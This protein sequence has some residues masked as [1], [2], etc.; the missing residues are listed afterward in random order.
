MKKQTW[1]KGGIVSTLLLITLLV[2]GLAVDPGSSGSATSTKLGMTINVL[3]AGKGCDKNAGA[4]QA[5]RNQGFKDG[6]FVIGQDK[7][8]WSASEANQRG[9][10]AFSSKT[11]KSASE[12]TKQLASKEVKAQ[13]ALVSLEKQAGATEA[14]MLD[15][16]NW[17][18]A[19]FKVKS[20]W[21]G[22]TSY[23][24]GAV[25]SAGTR[26][27]DT[28]DV[29]WLFVH[30]DVCVQVMNGQVPPENAVTA[31]R[32]GCGNPQ[33][34]LPTPVGGKPV[35]TVPPTSLPPVTTVPT[36]PTTT[37]LT[38]KDPSKDVLLNPAVPPA[39]KGSGTTPV[40]TSPGPATPVY[41]TPCGLVSCPTPTTSP[42]PPTPTAPPSTTPVTPNPPAS[43]D[44]GAPPSS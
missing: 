5:L 16:K 24:N 32:A 2:V 38:P 17:V 40:G 39:V 35:P 11:P 22:N 15:A 36:P 28:G 25:V 3:V 43:G 31:D 1:M 33:T 18:P 29:V 44:P 6:Q 14:Q 20:E 10:T 8:D 12:L 26:K 21:P 19:Q 37:T 42:P 27:S 7:I 30:P 4:S 23:Q 41:D 13:T 9:S 34:S